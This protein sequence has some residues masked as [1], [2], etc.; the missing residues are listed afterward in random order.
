MP[1]GRCDQSQCLRL[2]EVVSGRPPAGLS[3]SPG[4]HGAF[5]WPEGG[6]RVALGWLWG[7][8]PLAINTLWGG[9]GVALGGV[10]RLPPASLQLA[11]LAAGRY[12]PLPLPHRASPIAHNVSKTSATSAA[13][14][15]ANWMVLY[16]L[17]FEPV[18]RFL[19]RLRPRYPQHVTKLAQDRLA[20]RARKRWG[21]P[22][23]R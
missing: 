8:Y 21:Q 15:R 10:R 14:A 3:L 6:F 9:F 2:I 17:I 18:T 11:P 7:A 20:F 4:Y 16:Y 13:L 22:T 23:E 19:R 5:P 12:V 1:R